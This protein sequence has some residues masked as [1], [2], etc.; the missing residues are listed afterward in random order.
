MAVCGVLLNQPHRRKQY[1]LRSWAQAW[2]GGLRFCC[3]DLLI[4]PGA[5]GCAGVT[6]LGKGAEVAAGRALMKN[7]ILIHFEFLDLALST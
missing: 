5:G 7:M 1:A 3:Q 6:G 2:D 4:M